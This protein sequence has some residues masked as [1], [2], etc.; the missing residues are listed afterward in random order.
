MTEDVFIR[1]IR[2]RFFLRGIRCVV[3]L[4]KAENW[5]LPKGY[6][7]DVDT[8]QNHFSE[9]KFVNQKIVVERNCLFLNFF[10]FVHLD[11]VFVFCFFCIDS[12]DDCCAV[13]RRMLSSL[14]PM[15]TFER[16]G[17]R[18]RRQRRRP[19]G[20]PRPDERNIYI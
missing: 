20:S 3:Q 11:I 17:W 7:L 15:Q 2:N 10:L 4:P 1:T 16:R 8:A 6:S 19:F 14:A 13:V 9:P 5:K 12:L 18:F